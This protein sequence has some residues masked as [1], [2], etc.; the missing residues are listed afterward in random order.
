MSEERVSSHNASKM[1]TGL[2]SEL[3]R[4]RQQALMTWEKVADDA[5]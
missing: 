2:D 3:G 5:G 1:P 4:L